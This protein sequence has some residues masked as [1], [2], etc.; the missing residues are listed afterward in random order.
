MFMSA[1]RYGILSLF[2]H[3]IKN[4]HLMP[5]TWIKLCIDYNARLYLKTIEAEK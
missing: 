5:V 3:K 1:P 2:H 4:T